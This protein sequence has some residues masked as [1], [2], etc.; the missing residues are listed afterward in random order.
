MYAVT[1]NVDDKLKLASDQVASESANFIF[2]SQFAEAHDNKGRVRQIRPQGADWEMLLETGYSFEDEDGTA[3]AKSK[4]GK[5][6]VME[7]C[8]RSVHKDVKTPPPTFSM[9]APDRVTSTCERR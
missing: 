6:E 1:A 8:L 2:Q 4:I 5:I 7:N 9:A 3:A